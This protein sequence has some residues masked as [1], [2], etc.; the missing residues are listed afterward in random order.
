MT[1]ISTFVSCRGH[2]LMERVGKDFLTE[3]NVCD[4]RLVFPF[5]VQQSLTG[6]SRHWIP[7]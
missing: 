3:K 6:I 4:K 2:V 1:I 7:V 5:Y